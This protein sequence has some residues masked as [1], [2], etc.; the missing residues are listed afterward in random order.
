MSILG[1]VANLQINT[2]L[3]CPSLNATVAGQT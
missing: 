3:S 2:T 1:T